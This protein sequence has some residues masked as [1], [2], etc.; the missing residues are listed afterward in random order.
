MI[1]LA[2]YEAEKL[3]F[4]KKNDD[5]TL[6]GSGSDIYGAWEI[7]SDVAYNSGY[8]KPLQYSNYEVESCGN[9]PGGL[10]DRLDLLGVL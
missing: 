7:L 5:K 1:A 9:M 3:I 4:G 2:G 6:L 8:F 10:D